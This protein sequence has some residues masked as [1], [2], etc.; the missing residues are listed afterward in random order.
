MTPPIAGPGQTIGKVIVHLRWPVSEAGSPLSAEALERLTPYITRYAQTL[1]VLVHAVGGVPDHLH[2]LIE[3]PISRS[4]QEITNE[5]QGAT[6]RFLRNVLGEARFAWAGDGLLF[7]SISLS[8]LQEAVEY[9]HNQVER[10]AAGELIATMEG[11]A[12]G[13]SGGGAT[14]EMPAWLRDVLGS[15][16]GK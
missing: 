6:Q 2:L 10:H 13:E 9:I 8:G 5:L 3:L 15:K 12:D 14:E 1:G 11:E 16:D 4:L 7:A